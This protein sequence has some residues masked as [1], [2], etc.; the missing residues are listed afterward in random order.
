MKT[1]T[2][3]LFM[4]LTLTGTLNA[5][6]DIN[7]QLPAKEILELADAQLAPMVL[8]DKKTENIVLLHRN[9]YNSIAELSETEMRLAGLRINPV[10]NIGSRMAYVNNFT[11]MKVG[12]KEQKQVAGLPAEPRL[13]NFSWSPDESKMA[14]T[15]TTSTGVE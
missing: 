7:Y 13:T 2:T 10:T 11:L 14:F 1:I 3:F 15:N 9:R 8:M 6:I 12:E 5:Q 4:L